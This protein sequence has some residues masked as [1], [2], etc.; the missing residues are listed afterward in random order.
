MEIKHANQPT[1]AAATNGNGTF[2]I[3]P[4][5]NAKAGSPGV[6]H[7][8]MVSSLK[9]EVSKLQNQLSTMS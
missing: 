1:L 9:S 2:I 6:D 8:Q 3:I 7:Q 5:G 4:S